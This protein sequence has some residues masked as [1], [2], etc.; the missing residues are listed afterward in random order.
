ML[1]GPADRNLQLVTFSNREQRELR[2]NRENYGWI[3]AWLPLCA[4]V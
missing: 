1:A 4:A 2:K 3:L